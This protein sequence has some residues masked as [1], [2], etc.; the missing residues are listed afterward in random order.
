MVKL[1]V[2]GN[3]VGTL[4]DAGAV[5]AEFITKNQ[6]VE[7]R[8]ESGALIGAFIPAPLPAALDPLV[9][10]DPSLTREELDRRATEPG[11]AIEEVRKRLG[12]A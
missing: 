9:P 2:A 1:F 12:W 10:W 5:L 3:V 8:D 11:V 6:P 4:A 7:F